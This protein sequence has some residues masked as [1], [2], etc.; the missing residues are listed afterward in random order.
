VTFISQHSGRVTAEGLRW[1]V[2]SICAALAEQG[3]PI[4]PS[5]YYDYRARARAR[6]ASRLAQA[7]DARDTLLRN[8]IQR[9]WKENYR[10]YGARK[11]WLQLNREGV[12]VA[13]CTVERLMRDLGLEGARRGRK[14]RTTIADPAAA[15]PAD[16]VQRNFTPARPDRLWVADFTYCATWSGTVYVAFVIDAFSRR[17]LGWRAATTM[18][19]G[20]VLDALEMAIWTRGRQGVTDLTGLIAHHDAGSQY[21]SIAHT[22][23]LAAAGAA[24]SVGSVGDAYDNALAE[25]EIGLFKTEV[26]HR[27]GPWRGLD[28]IELAVLEWVDWH[29]HRR[30][31]SA[32]YDLPPA[33]YEQVYHGQH[34]AQRP[35]QPAGVSTP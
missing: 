35:Q 7:T 32:C 4:A 18:R 19:T 33:E 29:N 6:A 23:R 16:L 26:I 28:D 17:I 2:E 8:E 21:T 20:L 13:R 34:P 11:V 14:H 25:T 12:P 22:E 15:R 10:V 24:P 9:V 1:G 27:R 31:H 3:T 30:L 5:T